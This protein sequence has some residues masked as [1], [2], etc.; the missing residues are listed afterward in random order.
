M[1]TSSLERSELN[2]LRIIGTYKNKIVERKE[3]ITYTLEECY[4]LFELLNTERCPETTSLYN[5]ELLLCIEQVQADENMLRNTVME[6]NSM[7][8][9]YIMSSKSI[10]QRANTVEFSFFQKFP[11]DKDLP[12]DKNESSFDF[13]NLLQKQK[14]YNIEKTDIGLSSCKRENHSSKKMGRRSIDNYSR[15]DDDI[16]REEE[17]KRGSYARR[18]KLSNATTTMQLQKLSL[19]GRRNTTRKG[20]QEEIFDDNHFETVGQSLKVCFPFYLYLA[21]HFVRCKALVY[22][23]RIAYALEETH[24]VLHDFQKLYTKDLLCG[25]GLRSKQKLESQLGTGRILIL[26]ANLYFLCSSTSSIVNTPQLAKVILTSLNSSFPSSSRDSSLSHPLIIST[27]GSSIEDLNDENNKTRKEIIFAFLTKAKLYYQKALDFVPNSFET[28]RLHVLYRLAST[29]YGLGKFKEALKTWNLVISHGPTTTNNSEQQQEIDEND[30]YSSG[31]LFLSQNPYGKSYSS[32]SNDTIF[33]SSSVVLIARSFALRILTNAFMFLSWSDIAKSKRVILLDLKAM[34]RYCVQ[35]INKG[36]VLM[37]R[38][39]QKQSIPN[40]RRKFAC[41]FENRR[42]QRTSK[43]IVEA[44]DV[45]TSQKS[46]TDLITKVKLCLRLVLQN[47]S[48]LFE[49]KKLVQVLTTSFGK[50]DFSYSSSANNTASSSLIQNLCSE[51]LINHAM[52]DLHE[53]K[54]ESSISQ[55]HYFAANSSLAEVGLGASN[56]LRCKALL[57]LSAIYFLRGET[58]NAR[59][60]AQKILEKERYC[61]EAHNNIGNCFFT[62]G[63]YEQARQSYVNALQI[64]ASLVTATVN[65]AICTTRKTLTEDFHDINTFESCGKYLEAIHEALGFVQ[66]ALQALYNEVATNGCNVHCNHGENSARGLEIPEVNTSSSHRDDEYVWIQILLRA[67][68][69][70]RQ[71][72]TLDYVWNKNAN[73]TL[74]QGILNSCRNLV[75]VPNT[76]TTETMPIGHQNED[77]NHVGKRR[78]ITGG[79]SSSVLLQSTQAFSATSAFIVELQKMSPNIKSSIILGDDGSHYNSRLTDDSSKNVKDAKLTGTGSGKNSTTDTLKRVTNMFAKLFDQLTLKAIS[80]LESIRKRLPNDSSIVQQLISIYQIRFHSN[81]QDANN[82]RGK[83]AESSIKHL[84]RTPF[85]SS[86]SNQ[87]EHHTTMILSS[88]PFF[89]IRHHQ[90]TSLAKLFLSNPSIVSNIAVTHEANG[91][92]QSALA[93]WLHLIRLEPDRPS[94]HLAALRCLTSILAP[95]NGTVDRN[96][97]EAKIPQNLYYRSELIKAY[98][99]II[100]L[101]PKDNNLVAEALTI[102]TRLLGRNQNSIDEESNHEA[103]TRESISR[104]VGDN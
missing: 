32:S 98:Y 1:M 27:N 42:T 21:I 4:S 9:N 43:T 84:A 62:N 14:N 45:Q 80:D 96:K 102:L 31:S 52:K 22:T 46:I 72:E 69:Y 71:V 78:T 3:S 58:T 99:E 74:H 83:L 23:G 40:E 25:A 91:N 35:V 51:L 66:N 87:E 93:V 53:R 60:C 89:N 82:D 86:S 18:R 11:K 28:L 33:S 85:L 19:E 88:A 79:K 15:K 81:V 59:R 77:G 56:L 13:E 68:L 101:F 92:S 5:E 12:Y 41:H 63:D 61:A 104:G 44:N 16:R 75:F 36:E 95:K 17:S 55:L 26:I 64:D 90:H 103:K 2:S 50:L 7:V 38:S 73:K 10:T 37:T 29:Q 67:Q 49:P 70:Q 30:T 100:Y 34:T 48:Y 24:K 65:L 8:E 6:C 20:G 57:N 94:H 39:E 47:L 76:T 97:L 54:I